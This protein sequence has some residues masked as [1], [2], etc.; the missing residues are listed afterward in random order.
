MQA[1]VVFESMF[2]NTAA[3]ARAIAEG[4][5]AR[6]SVEAVEVNAAPA[7][8]FDISE[9][10]LL[11]VGGPTHA[12][13]MTRKTTRE[14]AARRSATP[15]ATELGLREWLAG[16]RPAPRHI[17][18]AAFD[19]RIATPRLPGSAA[20]AATKRLRRMGLDIV[21]PAQSFYVSDVAGPLL[22]GELE[23]A[24]VWGATLGAASG[25]KQLHAA[26]R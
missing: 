20:T 6:M 3:V 7:R 24:L 17:G 8:P 23:R 18:A 15:I 22:E 19:T 14:D 12:F 10:T 25:A 21:A 13:S 11:I 16:L 1:L 4:L 26:V 9:L 5:S 2:G